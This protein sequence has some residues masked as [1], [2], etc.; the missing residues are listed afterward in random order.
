MKLMFIASAIA[1]TMAA[2]TAMA[3]HGEIKFFG[4]VTAQTCDLVPEIGGAINNMVQLGT[5]TTKG[6]GTTHEGK[7]INFVLKAK[8]ATA[9]VNAGE[10]GAVI[11][12]DGN[13]G[14]EGVVNQGGMATDAYV[15]LLAKNAQSANTKITSSQNSATFDKSKL[16][17]EGYEF[18]AQ[19][20]GGTNP[21][22]FR[23]ASAY[24]VT[25]K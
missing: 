14:T 19:L 16:A 10:L 17:G 6:D 21:G 18:S 5:V 1:M 12:W 4:N 8:D 22:D 3:S 7:A 24:V 25:Y 15:V 2:G 9:C 20:I 11:T 23:S 13:L